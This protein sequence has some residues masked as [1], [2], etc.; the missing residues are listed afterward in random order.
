MAERI[1]IDSERL[2]SGSGT[3]RYRGKVIVAGDRR[4]IDSDIFKEKKPLIERGNLIG[5]VGRLSYEKGVM[6]LVRAIPSILKQRQDLEFLI[7]GDGPLLGEI[8]NEVAVLELDNKVELSGWIPHDKLADYL[9]ELKLFVLPSSTEGLPNIVLEAMAC[10]TPV[11]VTSVGALPEIIKDK[12]T[13]FIMKDNSPES[14]A[15]GIMKALS[16]SHLGKVADNAR[17]LVE[18]KYTFYIAL[19]RYRDILVSLMMGDRSRE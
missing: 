7:G 18:N 11:L 3:E 8:K 5:Y 4:F 17:T 9:N 14:I 13:G 1:V 2:I 12:E 10:G 19:E 6:S 15:N 16:Y